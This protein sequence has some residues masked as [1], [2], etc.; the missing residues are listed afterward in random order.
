MTS[1][2]GKKEEQ[3]MKKEEILAKAQQ[4][5]K[6]KDLA[7]I[8]AQR[9]GAVWGACAGMVLAGIFMVLS[10]VLTGKS[11]PG[12]M[13]IAFV[14]DAF[15]FWVKWFKLHKRHELAIAIIYSIMTIACIIIH[16]IMLVDSS[17]IL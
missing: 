4:E 9:L 14:T 2:L 12:F 7:D 8:E 1:K 15:I 11:S 13:A 5:N 17:T 3:I 6:K 16:I 10:F